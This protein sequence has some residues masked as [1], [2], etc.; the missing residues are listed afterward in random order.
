MD[1]ELHQ[2]LVCKFTLFLAEA[3]NQEPH[4]LIF[5]AQNENVNYAAK[6]TDDLNNDHEKCGQCI[7]EDTAN[8]IQK[9]SFLYIVM[10]IWGH[11]RRASAEWRTEMGQDKVC[12][13]YFCWIFNCG[14][15]SNA[16]KL[17]FY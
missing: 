12:S 5:S 8:S 7:Q 6:D 13:L 9:I 14:L 4:P 11:W 2:P 15:L 10:R 16:W 3:D 17:A 1:K